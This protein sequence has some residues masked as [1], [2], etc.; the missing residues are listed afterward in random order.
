MKVIVPDNLK[1]VHDGIIACRKCP[2]LRRYCERVARIKRKAYRDQEYWG[3]PVPGFGDPRARILIVGLAPAAH[4]GNRT[5]RV[6]TGD[7]SGDFLFGALYRA[8]F[9]NQPDSRRRDDGLVL[10][11]VYITA[12]VRCAPPANKPSRIERGR[13]Q[14]YLLRELRLLTD[15][16]IVIALGRIAFEEYL[17]VLILNRWLSSR[18]GLRFLHGARYP[19]KDRASKKTPPAGLPILFASY[20]PSQQNTQTGRLTAEMFD[21]VL[22]SVQ[23]DLFAE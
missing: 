10:M 23:T 9:S 5:G 14:E 17:N 20:H 11:G 22:S 8:G 18:R 1:Q 3:R 4:G 19:L 15:L 12:A 16:K 6:F 21:K 7:R 13:C 2:R